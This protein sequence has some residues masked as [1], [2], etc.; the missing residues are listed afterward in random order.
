MTDTVKNIIEIL[1]LKPLTI[2]GGYYRETYRS[3]ER[4][5]QEHLPQRYQSTRT[6]ATAIYYLLTAET[7][8][9]LHK[10]PTD[11]IF[12][13]YMG[14]PVEMLQLFDDG[15]GKIITI[16]ND[17]EKGYFP[18]VVVPKFTWQGTKLVEGGEFALF[19]TTTAPGFEFEDFIAPDVEELIK[20]Y[21]TFEKKIRG[22]V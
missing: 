17:L 6:F 20:K 16:G 12:H 4:V 14:D 5:A 8:S 13:F 7:F 1:D 3:E 18:Q 22:L 11:E 9:S 19:G 21:P 15:T 10:L 2:E